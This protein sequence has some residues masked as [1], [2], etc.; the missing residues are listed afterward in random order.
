MRAAHTPNVP[1]AQLPVRTAC[2]IG[3]TTEAIGETSEICLPRHPECEPCTIYAALLPWHMERMAVIASWHL[4]G[5]LIGL[6]P[7]QLRRFAG[8]RLSIPTLIVRKQQ[9]LSGADC[10][11]CTTEA[12]AAHQWVLRS[13]HPKQQSQGLAVT[14]CDMRTC[15]D[16]DKYC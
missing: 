8:Y 7:A 12:I 2:H 3:I 9:Y 4:A 11:H 6:A 1:L 13:R 5:E 16:K 15:C 10:M 14:A